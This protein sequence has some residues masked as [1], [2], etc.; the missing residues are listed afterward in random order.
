MTNKNTI[1]KNCG[2]DITGLYCSSCGQK[3]VEKNTSLKALFQDVFSELFSV[4]SKVLRSLKPL[5][6]KP[7]ELSLD[8]ING[9][10]DSYIKPF[11]L[12]LFSSLLFFFVAFLDLGDDSETNRTAINE[13]D[14]TATY[15]LSDTLDPDGQLVIH[16]DTGGIR[17]SYF[18]PE[19]RLVDVPEDTTSPSFLDKK[20]E[21]MTYGELLEKEDRLSTSFK[22]S[23]PNIMFVLVP[24]FAFVFKLL[25][26]RQKRFYTG[27]LIFVFH[28]HAFFFI[29][30]LFYTIL[31]FVFDSEIF[32]SILLGLTVFSF[33]VY[34]FVAMRC[35]FQQSIV[36]TLV[37]LGILV[38]SYVLIISLSL[39]AF[40]FG[41][42]LML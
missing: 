4:D 19:N 1:C 3:N 14:S 10:R 37:K 41:S 22:D 32:Q 39:L 13:Q 21:N 34:I 23:I 28:T 24:V 6:F 36:V 20:F 38:F 16:L 30:L 33:F 15:A 40:I 5:L 8:Y 26:I 25:Y 2:T 35:V 17:L 18:P 12:Y 27:H 7:G 11:R 42:V 9:K 29:L 31:G